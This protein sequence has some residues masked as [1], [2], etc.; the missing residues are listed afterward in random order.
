VT[1]S[2][3]CIN[4]RPYSL[5]AVGGLRINGA[6]AGWKSFRSDRTKSCK[7]KT[8]TLSITCCAKRSGEGTREKIWA[9]E[10]A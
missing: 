2:I 7:T 6:T 1:R 9:S 5:H 3:K 4:A 10:E 8:E